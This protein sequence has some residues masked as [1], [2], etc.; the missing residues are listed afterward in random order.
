[1]TDAVQCVRV[2][3]RVHGIFREKGN[4]MAKKKK[5]KEPTFEDAER[6]I[7]LRKR[8]KKG[9]ELHRDDSAFCIKMY[10]KFPEWYSETEKRVFNETVPFGSQVRWD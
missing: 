1:L 4:V 10:E 2:G 8:A 6:C 5:T 9:D 3:F 7:S